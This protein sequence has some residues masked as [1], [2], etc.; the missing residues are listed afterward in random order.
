MFDFD[1]EKPSKKIKKETHN[2]KVPEDI[3][4]V[5]VEVCTWMLKR[6]VI[7]ED[8]QVFIH[9]IYFKVLDSNVSQK[10]VII[11]D[12]KHWMKTFEPI[13]IDDLA[14]HNKKVQEVEDWVK[15]VSSNNNSDM[16]LMTGPVGCGKTISLRVLATKY[17]VRISEWITP[18]DIDIPSENGNL[19]F[20]NFTD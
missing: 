19:Q 16:L 6:L 14:V 10:P 1:E 17:N 12:H 3:E 20:F 4:P 2:Q 18:V 7:Y 5:E 13:N 9:F 15:T 11:T 8:C